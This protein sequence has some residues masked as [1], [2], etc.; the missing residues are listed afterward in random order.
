M[1]IR[2]ASILTAMVFA[3]G[4]VAEIDDPAPEIT[5]IAGPGDSCGK[6]ECGTNSP[7]IDAFDFHELKI[8][9]SVGEPEN[10]F[11][12]L[13]FYKQEGATLVPYRLSVL[14][15]KIFG[16]ASG[17]P[18]LEHQAL[19]GAYMRLY[20]PSAGWYRLSIVTVGAIA[21]LATPG[22]HHYIETYEFEYV[23]TSSRD[24][25]TVGTRSQNLCSHPPSEP[26]ETGLGTTLAVVFEGDRIE[27]ATKT[28]VGNDASWFNF[29]CANHALAKMYL[30]GHVAIAANDGMPTTALERQTIL[31]MYAADYCGTG[32]P[33]TVAGV[34]L[35][36]RDNHSPLWLDY[37][38]DP[39]SLEARW[40]PSG[41]SCL[42]NPRGTVNPTPDFTNVFGN[43]NPT[44]WSM[45]IG[46]CPMITACSDNNP[47][48]QN[49]AYLVTGNP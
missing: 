31:K 12:I 42:R 19:V 6:W 13:G 11:R 33:F 46:V 4:C 3:G 26:D 49:G 8:N 24:V 22:A 16:T 5:P 28:V 17:H 30:T 35:R 47:Q 1:T 48:L 7:K 32:E 18:T 25:V 27:A 23:P 14:Q 15:G 36:Y 34:K 39:V 9:G 2:A 41:A 43:G 37:K 40:S 45:V 20:S 10:D 38:S 21:Y 44:V 29:G